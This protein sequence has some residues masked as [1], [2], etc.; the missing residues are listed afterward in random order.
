MFRGGGISTFLSISTVIAG[1][2]IYEKYVWE[3]FEMAGQIFYQ[4][5]IN[6]TF[7]PARG[8]CEKP[9]LEFHKKGSG[10]SQVVEP[11]P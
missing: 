7:S 9:T 3:G 6:Y 10:F 1:Y 5:I 11:E 4:K 8:G 2:V